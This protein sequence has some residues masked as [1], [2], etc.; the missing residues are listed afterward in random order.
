MAGW[1]YDKFPKSAPRAVQGGIRAESK[2]GVFGSS[3]WGKR[4]NDVLNG[5]NI[6]ARLNRGRTY[7]RQGQVISIDIDKGVVTSEVQG[8]RAKP[9]AIRIQVK[10]IPETEWKKIIT[11][12]AGE[13]RFLAKLLAGEMPEEIEDVFRQVGVALFPNQAKDLVTDCSCPDW[14]NPC[15]HI[16]A[17]YLL[18]GEVFDKEPFLIFKLRGMER[19]EL[20]TALGGRK[21]A[22]TVTSA[23]S[24]T[25]EPLPTDPDAFWRGGA[26]PPDLF[27][28]VAP[29]PVDAAILKRLGSIPLWRGKNPLL[30]VLGGIYPRAAQKGMAIFT[31]ET[32][33]DTES[34]SFPRQTGGPVQSRV[35]TMPAHF[36]SIH[37]GQTDEQAA[38][39]SSRPATSTPVEHVDT[40]DLLSCRL[41]GRR[42]KFLGQHLSSSHRMKPD[43]Y[44]THFKLAADYP[45][46]AISGS[47]PRQKDLPVAEPASSVGKVPV[48][49]TVDAVT[50]AG[51]VAKIDVV[52]GKNQEPPSRG[53]VKRAKTTTAPKPVVPIDQAVSADSVTCLLCGHTGVFLKGH[54]QGRHSLSVDAYR[55]LFGLPDTFPV[56]APSYS[57]K[58]R[59]GILDKSREKTT[60]TR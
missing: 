60:D 58:R 29:P 10:T 36:I 51:V 50:Q 59:S 32:R 55:K 52:S 37:P 43:A 13:A 38:E 9:Y 56:V 39:P 12:M 7:A 27:G 40:G 47:K 8:S 28:E 41:C 5:F 22:A 2:R 17:V 21:G 54:L 25:V 57:E 6:G 1:F 53:R 20:L 3:W 4:W 26:I 30:E 31:G 16:A 19:S 15:K 42:V 45:M 23:A 44:R 14:S 49:V 34:D 46:A 48:F 24:V 33:S 11:A 18:L 35:S